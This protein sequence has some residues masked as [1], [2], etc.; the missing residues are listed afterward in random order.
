MDPITTIVAVAASKFFEAW[1]TVIGE[2][3]AKK[4]GLFLAG[5]KA[6]YKLA[7]HR[8]IN[9]YRQD[10]SSPKAYADALVLNDGPLGDQRVTS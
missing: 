4:L 10:E 8:T 2:A 3:A 5:E 7:L 1:I 9:W 6:A